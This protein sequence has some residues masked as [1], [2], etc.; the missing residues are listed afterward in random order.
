MQFIRN[1]LTSTTIALILFIS[2]LVAIFSFLSVATS[3]PAAAH[4]TP[5]NHSVDRAAL[6]ALY[7]ATDGENW[8]DNTN[9]LNDDVP[10]N[11]WYG[12]D[13]D[14]SG[15]VTVLIFHGNNLTGTIPE[16]LGRLSYLVSL[17]LD[18]NNLTGTIPRELGNLSNLNE[19][20]LADNAL[21]GTIP[22]ELGSMPSLTWLDLGGNSLR[23]EIPGELGEL[24]NL[25]R[26]YLWGNE[27]TGAI[28]E[29]LGNL[30]NLTRLA[31]SDNLLT[32]AIPHSLTNLTELSL[33][34]FAENAGLCV[35]DDEAFH[36]WL[37]GISSRFRADTGPSCSDA[38]VRAAE[39]LDR[40]D[41]DGSGQIDLSEVSLAIDDYFNG[42]LTLVE[43]S[44]VID[45]YFG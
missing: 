28:P 21:T 35:P 44:I 16:E 5:H 24:S 43:V 34:T 1:H 31:L 14:A 17:H 7:N 15:R 39:L 12:V 37:D 19:L 32:G 4:T 29:E 36:A 41:T 13:T 30:S 10:F 18:D 25:T 45:L 2:A 11:E 26:L 23:G 42:Q 20:D 9:W 22:K 33:F 8:R 6:G 38:G 27:L 40:Y 3:G